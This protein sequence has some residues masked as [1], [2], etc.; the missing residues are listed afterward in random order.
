MPPETHWTEQDWLAHVQRPLP[1]PAEPRLAR[2]L[3]AARRQP[4][5]VERSTGV[6][7]FQCPGCRDE[8]HDRHM[9]NAGL[10]LA[11]GTWGCAVNRAHWR[12]IGEVLGAF[13]DA[14]LHRPSPATANIPERWPVP[15]PLV[16]A[17]PPVPPFDPMRLLPEALAAWVADV[18]E[19]A[20]CPPDF[21]GIGVVISAGAVIGRQLAIRP[22]Q[23][24]DWTVVPNVWGMGIAPPGLMKSAAMQ[25]ALRGVYALIA[26]ARERH[27]HALT[28]WEF[29]AASAEAQRHAIEKQMKRAAERGQPLASFRDAL[30]A[31]AVPARPVER[32]YLVNDAIVE[33][34]GLLLTENPNGL[35]TFR[36]EL[37]GWLRLM[38]RE[39]HENDR[40]FF[41]EAWNGTGSY[42]YDRIGRGTLHIPAACL[43]VLGGI[44]PLPLSV[45]L[46]EA[47]AHGQDDGLIQ[48]FQL[49]VWPDV[50]PAWRNVDRLPDGDARRRVVEVFV[51]LDALD[52]TALGAAEERGGLPFLRFD[53]EAQARFD[54]WRGHLETRLRTEDASSVLLAHLAKYRSLCPSLALIFN[55]IDCVDAGR[56]GRVPLEALTRALAW[57]AYLEPHARRVYDGVVTPG[58][59][60]AATLARHLAAG[61]L[62]AAFTVRDVRLKGW[63]GLATPEEILAALDRLEVLAWVRRETV[64]HAE[65]GRPTTR[66]RVNPQV[67]APEPQS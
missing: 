34:L 16:T 37:G 48:R 38:D 44:Q 27:R 55:V 15:E 39:G 18:A 26:H 53:A 17:L 31:A 40:S 36:D 32:R 1:D 47:F 33:K 65:G 13:D 20:Q 67:R 9:D 24:D 6:C 45:Y 43:S 25:E 21:V 8:G 64:R 56:G 58:R 10:F 4:G 3:A 59:Q 29:L 2:L 41:C 50:T 7:K 66:Y 28:E 46:R 49:M 57:V 23:R 12:A 11:E 51:R 42:T 63:V 22:K 35:L 19:R 30:A 5:F 61:D 52:L 14:A 54:A 62:P 60:A